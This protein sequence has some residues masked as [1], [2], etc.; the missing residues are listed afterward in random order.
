MPG[1]AGN[2]DAKIAN[3]ADRRG[4]A[5]ITSTQ[6][7]PL[8]VAAGYLVRHLATGRDMPR[9][10]QNVMDLWRP[11]IEEQAGG[12]LD[13]LDDVLADQAAFA[14][15]ARKVIADLG[16]GDQLGDDPDLPED[17]DQGDEAQEDEDSPESAGEESQDSEE[18]DASPE[19]SQEEQQDQSQ[20]Q[21]TMEDSADM[22]QGD[23]TELPEGEAPLEPP[24]PAPYSDAD[25]NYAVYTTDFDE[26]IRAE[27]LA[28]PAELEKSHDLDPRAAR[29]L[30]AYLKRPVAGPWLSFADRLSAYLQCN[31][32]GGYVV[33]HNNICWEGFRG[34]DP[35][36]P[37]RA[38]WSLPKAASRA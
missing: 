13:V 18:S 30:V 35:L 31:A 9:G 12:T 37:K 1:T 14:R 8:S 26:E 10:A 29:N 5:Q 20:A 16:Y 19:Q 38:I 2:I 22:E 21:V 4:Y 6:E 3:E 7:A 23:E 28:E 33:A 32:C 11:F 27:E 17:D 36:A 15:L 25:P 34:I 24:P